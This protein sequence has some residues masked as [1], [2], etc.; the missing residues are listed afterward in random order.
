MLSK[1]VGFSTLVVLTTAVAIITATTTTNAAATSSRSQPMANNWAATQQSNDRQS[2]RVGPLPW[3]A[4]E[5]PIRESYA[6]NFPIRQWTTKVG[7]KADAEMFYWFFPALKP[8]V[9]NPPL[10]IW[11]QGGPGASSMIGLFYETGPIHVTEDHKLIRNNNTWAT[12]YSMLFIEQPVGT[13]YSFV[14]QGGSGKGSKHKKKSQSGRGSRGENDDEGDGDDDGDGDDTPEFDNEE[15]DDDDGDEDVRFEELDAE[16]ERDQEEEAAFFATLPSTHPFEVKVAAAASKR[17]R[18]QTGNND[19][20]AEDP[21]AMYTKA[22]YVKDQRAVVNDMMIFLDQF[23]ERYPE[24]QKV[25]LYIAGQSYAGKFIPSIAHAIMD[26]NKKLNAKLLQSGDGKEVE[27]DG[28]MAMAETI[29][30][31]T[32]SK[33]AT[34]AKQRVIPIKG[35][36]MGNTMTDP[37][38]QIQIHADHAYYLGLITEPQA[39]QMREYQRSAVELVKQGRYLDA[40]RFRGKIFNLFRNSTGGLNTFDIRK[41]S[42]GMNWKPM[43][44]LLNMPEIKDSLNVFGPRRSYLIQHNVPKQE[45]DRIERGRR[46]AEYKTDPEVKQAMRGDIMRSTKP[47]VA[48]LLDNGVKVLAYQGIFDFRDAPAGSTHW[49]ETLDWRL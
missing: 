19:S 23:Y 25:D 29:G 49:I 31:Q 11:L 18:G 41:G 32:V 34:K 20:K 47:L 40:N 45:V 37:I 5:D 10:I 15:E 42:H 12:E 27:A 16:L 39:D 33:T 38:T 4:G 48:S 3:A 21:D 9:E 8:K 26:R 43:T 22:G 44:A 24:Q 30:I 7:S 46:M 13:G 6:G 36:S 1:T 35:I 28:M 14:D 2:H 17:P